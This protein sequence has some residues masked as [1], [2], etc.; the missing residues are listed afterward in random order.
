MTALVLVFLGGGLGSVARYGVNVTSAALFGPHYPTGTLIV[1][2]AGGLIMGI[3]A[4]LLSH[5]G[6]LWWAGEARL[7]F[8]TG[9]LGG[10]TT[11]SAFSLDTVVLWQRGAVAEAVFYVAASVV[12]SIAAVA[13]GLW[14]ARA[15]S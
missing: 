12:L 14:L 1:N 9:I 7:F 4:G 6:A 2:V 3:V 5:R 15:F 10:F 11:F 13:A 8:M